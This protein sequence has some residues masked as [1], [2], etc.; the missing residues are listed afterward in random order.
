M[1]QNNHGIPPT[2]TPASEEIPVEKVRDQVGHYNDAVE[3]ID[4]NTSFG[5]PNIPMAPAHDPFTLGPKTGRG[6]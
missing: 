6:N 5:L 4:P 1:A 2:I 3:T